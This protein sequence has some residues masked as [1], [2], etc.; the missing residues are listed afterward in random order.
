MNKVCLFLSCPENNE[1]SLNAV[2]ILLRGGTEG[3]EEVINKVG[4]NL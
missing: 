4:K 2:F 1:I 3:G